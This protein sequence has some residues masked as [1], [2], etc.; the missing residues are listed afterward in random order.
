MISIIIRTQNEEGYIGHCLGAVFEQ[1][2]N[3]FEV[4]IV[5]NSSTDKT[6]PIARTFPIKEVINIIDYKPGKSINLGIEESR[7][8]IIVLLSAHCIPKSNQ[9]LSKLIANFT[10]NDIA[11]VYGRQLPVSYS[12]P[13]DVRELYI[14][15]GQEK[16]IQEKDYFFH[17]ANSAIRRSVWEKFPFDTKVTN[18]ED[19]MWAKAVIEKGY[20]LV[21]E[22]EAEVFH[23]HG[24]H[25][26][27]DEIRADQTVKVIKEVEEFKSSDFLPASLKP[28]NRNI[29]AMIPVVKKS[30][31]INNID[32]LHKLIND[33][34]SLSLISDIFIISCKSFI[35]DLKT[36]QKVRLMERPVSIYDKMAEGSKVDEM[37][38]CLEKINQ[39]GLFPDYII[40]F[41]PLYPFRPRNVVK[42]LIYD[43]CYKGLD[44]V[45]FGYT[46]KQSIWIKDI[47]KKYYQELANDALPSAQNRLKIETP[48]YRALMGIGCITRSGVLRSGQMIGADN[49]G[50]IP[51][52]D[53]KHT[54]TLADPKAVS[55]IKV[56]LND[57]LTVKV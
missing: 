57:H 8:E 3:E 28:E 13:S 6:I 22:P 43:A 24:I 41:D 7:G 44:S 33:L 2:E 5:D 16:R 52:D 9:W 31:P 46:E 32:L 56:L 21:Y 30:K 42:V 49:I 17:N 50:I 34:C 36:D 10:H 29:V 26:N 35:G 20:K 51:T 4:I 19:R 45:F 18:I 25:Q 48:L 12:K 27:Q 55:L 53:I 39:E 38:W 37:I 40:Y 11:G 23:H 14:S 1:E 54:L 47:N 15:F